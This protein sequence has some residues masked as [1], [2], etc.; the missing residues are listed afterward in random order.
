MEQ[1]SESRGVPRPTWTAPL[2]T[3]YLA[4]T[5][6]VR[7]SELTVRRGLATL[8][9]RLLRPTWNVRHKADERRLFLPSDDNYFSRLAC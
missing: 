8:G 3:E 6:G 7:V 2:L 1:G 5:T 9:Y 4:Q